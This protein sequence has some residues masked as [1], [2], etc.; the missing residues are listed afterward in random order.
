[1]VQRS[2]FVGTCKAETEERKAERKRERER[3]REMGTKGW[4]ISTEMVSPFGAGRPLWSPLFIKPAGFREQEG[5]VVAVGN[6]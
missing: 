5:P 6:F 1:M 2:Y 3:E 4:V